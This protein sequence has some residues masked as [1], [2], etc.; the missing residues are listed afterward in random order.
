[1]DERRRK[2]SEKTIVN[3]PLNRVEGDLEI[4]VQVEDHRVTD[5][6]CSGLLYRRFENLLVGRGPL[7]GLVITPRICGICS[8]AHLS[9]AAT[10]LD[11]V[12]SVCV[13]PAALLVRNLAL[14]TEHLQSDVR[15]TFLMFMADTV[16]GAYHGSPLFPEAVRRYEPL[17]G[18]VVVEVIEETKKVLEIIALFGGAWPHSSYMVPGGITCTPTR[19]EIQ[20]CLHHLSRYR[21]WY[22]SR[23]LGCPTERWLAVQSAQNLDE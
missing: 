15:Q 6:W 16:N 2:V 5:A 17:K 8:T 9:A 4:R 21:E 1:V 10:A 18:E 20:Q 19:V 14:A 11:M 13:P 3:I 22:E 12:A 23:I 7:D